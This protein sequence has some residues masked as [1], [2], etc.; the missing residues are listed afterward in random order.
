MVHRLPLAHTAAEPVYKSYATELT[1][2]LGKSAYDKLAE[3]CADREERGQ[4]AP[5]RPRPA[6]R[7]P[8]ATPPAPTGRSH[9][10]VRPH[11]RTAGTV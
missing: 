6:A 5:T 2:L 9:R 8:W 3:L 10:C 1:E 4:V 7:S 11:R